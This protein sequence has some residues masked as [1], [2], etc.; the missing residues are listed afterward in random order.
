MALKFANRVKVATATTGSGTITLGSPAVGFQSFA[1]GGISNADEVRYAI[2]DGDN[3]EVGT[4]TYTSAGT[5]LSRT[6]IESSTGSLLN[7]SGTDVEVFITMASIDVGSGG[8]SGGGDDKSFYLNDQ[9]VTSDYTI[10]SNKN[11]LTTGPISIGSGVT[12]T[13]ETGARWV[14]I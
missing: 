1:D 7:L 5:T 10:P 2:S 12:L 4:G 3:W 14:V 9:N 8:A 6:L 11:A 13:I